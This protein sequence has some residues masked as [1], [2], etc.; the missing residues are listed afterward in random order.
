M[1]R[2]TPRAGQRAEGRRTSLVMICAARWGF[3]PGGAANGQGSCSTSSHR[4]RVH[5]CG[6][7]SG[8][9]LRGFSSWNLSPGG[10]GLGTPL[11]V[12]LLGQGSGQ[13]H[14]EPASA[15]P[16]EGRRNSSSSPAAACAEL[17]EHGGRVPEVALL[18]ALDRW[19]LQVCHEPKPATR[20]GRP[21][22]GGDGRVARRPPGGGG[23]AGAPGH[24]RGLKFSGKPPRSSARIF[25][26]GWFSSSARG[27]WC[28]S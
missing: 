21:Q 4:G 28:P 24:V 10:Q 12:A 11:R 26:V 9:Q 18:L 14:P 2:G 15:S 19:C 25:R 1:L 16:R 22:A 23:E 27:L 8:H 5:V 3:V 13:G 20:T 6:E 17:G 7:I